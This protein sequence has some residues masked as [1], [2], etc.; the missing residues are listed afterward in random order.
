MRQLFAEGEGSSGKPAA[1]VDRSHIKIV[2]RQTAHLA[3]SISITE[4]VESMMDQIVLAVL[5]LEHKLRGAASANNARTTLVP[6]PSFSGCAP[7]L[8]LNVYHNTR[9]GSLPKQSHH[10]LTKLTMVELHPTS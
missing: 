9:L 3:P 4:E 1:W 8:V 6:G 2:D 10:K 7:L 5:A